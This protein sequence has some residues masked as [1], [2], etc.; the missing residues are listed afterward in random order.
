MKTIK[1]QPLT[2]AAF[3]KYGAFQNL[4]DNAEMAKSS[5]IPA[6]FFADLIPL[7]F[8]GQTPPA[9]SVAHVQKQAEMRI[10]SMETH[11]YTCEGLLPLD[12]DI[13]IFAGAMTWEDPTGDALEAF[14]V[15]KGTFVR[16]DPL[17]LHGTQFVVNADE[18]HILCLLPQRT[19]KNDLLFF[20]LDGDAGVKVELD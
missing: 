18:A 11:Q 10:G 9:V 6:G 20:P 4:F 16:L 7:H 15:P 14:L 12:A 17:V 5:V 1:P 19:F 3:R 2:E 8:G 13:I